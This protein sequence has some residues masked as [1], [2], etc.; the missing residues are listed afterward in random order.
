MFIVA[1]RTYAADKQRVTD[2]LDKFNFPDD[3]SRPMLRAGNLHYEL[4][5]RS[6]GTAY[7]GIGLIHQL[8]QAS[9][10]ARAIDR[11]LHLFKLHLPYH[12]S[13]HV[14]NL[15]Y[16]AL[17]GG[18]CLDD[19]ELRRQDE[20]YL[21]ALGALRIPDPTTAGDFCRRF[22]RSDLEDLQA[23]IDDA[24]RSNDAASV[25]QRRE[26]AERQYSWDVIAAQTAEFLKTVVERS[27]KE[28]DE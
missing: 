13:D 28:D 1:S 15:A 5:G 9:G 4:A 17:C 10:L 11:R 23:A 19:L 26:L 14:L 6:V 12:E 3:L 22:R 25:A 18:T 20:G 24:L 27:M 21:N 16:N 2:R 8:V 7:G